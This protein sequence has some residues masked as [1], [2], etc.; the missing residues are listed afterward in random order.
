MLVIFLV[1]IIAALAMPNVVVQDDFEELQQSAA[2]LLAAMQLQEEEAVLTGTQ[3]GLRLESGNLN[4]DG[5]IAYQWLVW[6]ADKMQWTVA[7][8]SMRQSDGVVN[9][10][11]EFALT[12]D[13]QPVEPQKPATGSKADEQQVPQIVIYSSGDIT[14]FELILRGIDASNAV[15]LKGSYEGLELD[16][17]REGESSD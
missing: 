15:T 12:I 14:D 1:G 17:D 13:G 5:E 7:E 11:V 2:Q 10:A 3:H 16:D 4:A 9:G 6:S 8:D